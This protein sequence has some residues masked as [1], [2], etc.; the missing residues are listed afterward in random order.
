MEQTTNIENWINKELEII[1]T[2]QPQTFE[3]KEALVLEENKIYSIEVDFSKQWDKWINAE[4]LV[5]KIIP[6]RY[7][8]KDLVFWL[9]TK[10]PLYK[11][12]LELGSKGQTSFNIIR[13]GQK[14]GTRYTLAK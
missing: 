3:K 2:E 4:G 9:N 6:I 5:K 14:K 11:D 7:Q 8:G 10:N 12:L 13:T 1:K